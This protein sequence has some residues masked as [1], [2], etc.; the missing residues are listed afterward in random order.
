VETGSFEGD[1]LVFHSEITTG[2]RT[3]KLRNVTRL[4]ATGTIESE[5]YV[6]VKDAPEKLLVQVVATRKH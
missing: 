3:M 1:A 4:T 6:S 2:G 5:Q